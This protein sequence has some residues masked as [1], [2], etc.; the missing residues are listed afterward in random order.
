MLHT[1]SIS[2]W[3]AILTLVQNIGPC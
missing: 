1:I 3:Y 2:Y